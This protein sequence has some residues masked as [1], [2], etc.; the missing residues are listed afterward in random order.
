MPSL[1]NVHP[2]GRAQS[3]DAGWAALLIQLSG[4]SHVCRELRPQPILRPFNGSRRWL[5]TELCANRL[6][7]RQSRIRV[8]TRLPDGGFELGDIGGTRTGLN[9]RGGHKNRGAG[10]QPRCWS[11]ELSHEGCLR[12]AT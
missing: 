4:A 2:F 5:V 10:D 6:A 12:T 1:R 7:R 8:A 11:N 9:R 3:F